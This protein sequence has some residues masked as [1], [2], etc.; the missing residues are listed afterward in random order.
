MK[1]IIIAALLGLSIFG[2]AA[3]PASA[4]DIRVHGVF[5]GR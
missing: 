3:V 4:D 1:I 5:S 2:S